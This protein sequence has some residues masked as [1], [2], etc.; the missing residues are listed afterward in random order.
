MTSSRA[1]RFAG[2]GFLA[3]LGL[4]TGLRPRAQPQQPTFRST[5]DVVAVDVSVRDGAATVLGLGA[6]DFRIL[7]DGVPQTITDM[8][9]GKLPIDVTVALDVSYSERGAPLM[10]LEQAVLTLA[11]GLRPEDR[12]RL[13]A[14][15]QDVRRLLDF[16]E[17]RP[18]IAA[19]LRTIEP[20]GGT[21]IYDALTTALLAPTSPERRQLVMV[22][23]D[24]GD[25][26]SVTEPQ[27]LLAAARRAPAAA[28]A[29]LPRAAVPTRLTATT[30]SATPG[31]TAQVRLIAQ[32][33]EATGGRLV[34]D[35]GPPTDLGAPFRLALDAFRA[36]YVL[37]FTPHGV[38]RERRPYARGL[39]ARP[40][41]RHAARAHRILRRLS[42]EARDGPRTPPGSGLMCVAAPSGAVGLP[43]RHRRFDAHRL[44]VS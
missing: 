13:I 10:R 32:L 44:L 39:A 2:V 4:L 15:N 17:S 21:S 12:L 37:Y 1:R 22:F 19:A 34:V 36:S 42:V 8:S 7:D 18:A 14:F 3:G 20:G 5:V 27:Q 28:T 24:G 29:V 6:G 31:L 38:D 23:T 9:Y 30:P 43:R 25:T 41:A 16:S 11:E 33:T 40:P 35:P 26:A